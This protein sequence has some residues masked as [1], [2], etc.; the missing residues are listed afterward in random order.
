M[1]ALVS[2]RCTHS[3]AAHENG[4]C[5]V[6]R[7]GCPESRYRVIDAE[8]N[9]LKIEHAAYGATPITTSAA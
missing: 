7:C 6:P 4:G 5:S 3:I 2:C 8:I 9:R 1:E